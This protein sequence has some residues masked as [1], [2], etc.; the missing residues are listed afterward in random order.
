MKYKIYLFIFC[1]FFLTKFKSPPPPP[2]QCPINI[3]QLKEYAKKYNINEEDIELFGRDNIANNDAQ[4]SCINL[5]IAT[6]D[7]FT[8]TK[9]QIKITQ[10]NYIVFV[11]NKDKTAFIQEINIPQ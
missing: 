4:E 10:E 11:R 1:I 7:C 2:S 5:K 8:I 9:I 6:R 3:Q